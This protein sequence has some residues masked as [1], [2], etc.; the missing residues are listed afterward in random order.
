MDCTFTRLSYRQTGAFSRIAVDYV[1]H[2]Q[3]LIPFIAHLPS[4][5]G[6]Q[7]AIEARKQFP[8][9]RD[10]L[11]QELKKQYTLVAPSGAVQKN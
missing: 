10:V 7:E 8:T 2:S 4:I 9:N 1:D 3:T 5:S 11:V 6:I